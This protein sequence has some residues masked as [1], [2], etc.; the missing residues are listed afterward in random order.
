M[1]H[2]FE[3]EDDDDGWTVPESVGMMVMRCTDCGGIHIGM[4][5]DDHEPICEMTLNDEGTLRMAAQLLQAVFPNL[6]IE[7]LV[8]RIKAAASGPVH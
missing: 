4:M 2:I 5:D 8:E 1:A 3:E 6:D 7:T